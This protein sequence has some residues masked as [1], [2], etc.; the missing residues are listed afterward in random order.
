MSAQSL[1]ADAIDHARANADDVDRERALAALEE[2]APMPAT[3]IVSWPWTTVTASGALPFPST[4]T[5]SSVPKRATSR[6]AH[7]LAS[8]YGCPCRASSTHVSGM[9]ALDWVSGN[10]P[11]TLAC[12]HG[13]PSRPSLRRSSSQYGSTRA[14]VALRVDGS[15]V[16]L[17]VSKTLMG[18]TC[19]LGSRHA[20]KKGPAGS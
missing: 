1:F 13:V 2:A 16:K 15:P 18:M 14:S 4:S 8:V 17:G 7:S 9:T 12:H 11:S 19:Q 5:E 3:C 6:P 10:W 20:S